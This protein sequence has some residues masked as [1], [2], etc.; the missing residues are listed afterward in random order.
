MHMQFGYAL[1]SEEHSPAALAGH[2]GE[3]I[4][5]ERRPPADVRQQ[6]FFRFYGRELHPALE[7]LTARAAA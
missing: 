5:G 6:G 3:H 7:S 2:A 1:S 4:V